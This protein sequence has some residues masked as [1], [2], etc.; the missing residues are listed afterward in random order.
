MGAA[1]HEVG[2]VGNDTTM[3]TTYTTNQTLEGEGTYAN[4]K[5]NEAGVAPVMEGFIGGGINSYRVHANEALQAAPDFLDD[6]AADTSQALIPVDNDTP[7]GIDLNSSQAAGRSQALIPVDN[8]TPYGIDLNS[9]Q[10]AGHDLL[11]DV[12]VETNLSN[13]EH[14][15]VTVDISEPPAVANKEQ[16]TEVTPVIAGLGRIE[17][18]KSPKQAPQKREKI[19]VPERSVNGGK[20]VLFCHFISGEPAL[21]TIPLSMFKGFDFKFDY[22][23]A[24]VNLCDLMTPEE[25]HDAISALNETMRPSRS[26]T[27]DT[28]LLITGPL[29]VPLAFWGVRHSKLVKKRKLLLNEGI[30]NFNDTHPDLYM[31]YHRSSAASYL[32]IEKRK[33]EHITTITGV[34][35]SWMDREPVV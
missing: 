24:N 11:D 15:L 32:T 23:P 8:D 25:Y 35:E 30:V 9:S 27:L 21:T 1:I 4:A 16:S 19:T 26:K 29:I 3:N 17:R 22:D 34:E 33:D 14:A 13:D 31:H 20:H 2:A 5:Q 7:Y 28:G 10:A 6:Q 12:A 18:N